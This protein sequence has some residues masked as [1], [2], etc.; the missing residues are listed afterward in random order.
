WDHQADQ[1]VVYAGTQVP[2]L[3]RTGLAEFLQLPQE[4]V[5]VISP[6]VGGGFGYKC[7]LQREE[8]CVA[9]LAKTFKKP[10]RYLEDRREHLIAG[11]NTREHQYDVTAYADARGRLLA[12]DAKITIDSGAYS[13]MP[14]T[15]GLEAGQA[16]GNLPGPYDFKGYRCVS[17]AVATNKPGFVP[18]RGVARTGVCFAME[19]LL[20]AV[21]REVGREAWQV[22]LENLVT[23]SLMPHVNVAN[24]HMDSGD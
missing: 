19:L 12:L 18:Y 5:R 16:I 14:W 9:W 21:A 15:I 4:Q 22:R 3:V 11:A 23:G 24:K 8:V 10:F 6:D 17:Q 1:L 7:I 20:D 13:I 2:H